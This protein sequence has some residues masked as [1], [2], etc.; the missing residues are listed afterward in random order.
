MAIPRLTRLLSGFFGKRSISIPLSLAVTAASQWLFST[1]PNE[2]VAVMLE[3]YEICCG[4]FHGFDWC[5][6]ASGT[7]QERLGLLPPAQEHILRQKDG[8]DRYVRMVREL[9]QAF[10]LAVPHETALG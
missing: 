3:R 4:L 7:P 1:L 10:A 9:S 2:A 8:K 6:W 5:K